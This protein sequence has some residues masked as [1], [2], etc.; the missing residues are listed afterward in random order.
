[1][2][3]LDSRKSQFQNYMAGILFLFIFGFLSILAFV[4]FTATQDAFISSGIYVGAVEEAGDKFEE[5]LKLY[6]TVIVLVM[7]ILII[8][9]GVTSFRL[10]TSPIFFIISLMMGAIYGF[11]SFFF[12]FIFQQMVSVPIFTTAL[13][14]FPN[15]ILILTNLHWV[16]LVFVVVGSITLYAKKEKGQFLA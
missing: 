7:A 9:V 10:A 15:T 1:M 14:F 13:L 4:I 16:M 6:D 11:I 8:A 3:L 5:G 2:N 12:N